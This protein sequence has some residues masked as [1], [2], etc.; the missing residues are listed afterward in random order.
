MP[1]QTLVILSDDRRPY[2]QASL[3]LTPNSR[4]ES[5][6]ARRRAAAFCRLIANIARM[7]HLGDLPQQALMMRECRH[8]MRAPTRDSVADTGRVHH[9]ACRGFRATSCVP[10]PGIFHPHSPLLMITS[11]LLRTSVQKLLFCDRIPVAESHLRGRAAP[12]RLPA[13]PGD[14]HGF[15]LS[16]KGHWPVTVELCPANP[17][18][19]PLTS[20]WLIF[21]SAV[22]LV[23]R[24]LS[25]QSA[26]RGICDSHSR[27][28]SLCF[29]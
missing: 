19:D 18:L 7:V 13:N 11:L 5:S 9:A 16:P 29:P 27:P 28:L 10:V 2:D 1:P 25:S 14:S 23:D 21:P 20:Q 4:R 17:I 24:I 3:E 6:A 12:A 8:S 26:E 22:R 15:A